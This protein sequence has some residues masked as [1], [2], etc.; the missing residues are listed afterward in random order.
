MLIIF[1]RFANLLILCCL[2]ILLGSDFG[3]NKIDTMENVNYFSFS[4][5]NKD[6]KRY[7]RAKTAL[8]GGAI[9]N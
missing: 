2:K 8:S 4:L 9:I 3:Q 7:T 1:D 6:G 5:S